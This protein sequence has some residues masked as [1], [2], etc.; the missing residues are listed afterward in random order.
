MT[1][2]LGKIIRLLRTESGY[3]QQTLADTIG[4]SRET[5]NALEGDDANAM[6][7]LKLKVVKSVWDACSDKATPETKT[8]YRDNI[9]NSFMC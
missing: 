9:I 3:T 2:S 7:A 8:L 4:L 5:I 1:I 6:H